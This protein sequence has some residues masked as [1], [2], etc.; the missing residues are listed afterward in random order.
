MRKK[1]KRYSKQLVGQIIEY[2]FNYPQNNSLRAIADIFEIN[3]TSVAK[4]ISE[5]LKRRADN[6]LSKRC[7]KY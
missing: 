2:Y 7:S 4:I 6:S 5:E 1:Y 3:H